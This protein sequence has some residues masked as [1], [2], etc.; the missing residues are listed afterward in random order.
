M[1]LT[2]Q[3]IFNFP[4]LSKLTLIAG[5]GGLKKNV[6]HCGIL[7]YEYDKDVSKKY[8]DYNYQMDGEFLTLTTFLYAKNDPNL[9]YDA[10]KN[11][12][13]KKG[14]GLII[15]NIFKLPISD[16]VIRYANHMNFP[17]FVLNDSYPFFEDIIILINKAMERYESFYYR[18]QK[19]NLLLDESTGDSHT[20][21]KLIYDI[22]PSIQDDILVI[23]FRYNKGSLGPQAYRKIESKIYAENFLSPEDSVFYYENGFM[24]ILSGSGSP[25]EDIYSLIETG[26]H[27]LGKTLTDDFRIGISSIHNMR[28]ELPEAI[29]ESFYALRFSGESENPYTLFN[30]LGPYRAILPN[31]E[32]PH[33]QRYMEDYISPLEK[34][35]TE[36]KSDILS[37]VTEFVKCGGD[38]EKTGNAMGQHKNTIRYRMNRAGEILGINPFAPG[39]YEGLALA[40]R[41]YICS[42]A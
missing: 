31:A 34:Y 6:S 14:S 42:I 18:E 27:T 3:D 20:I 2:V 19:V 28:E 36:K 33:M 12:V 16:N 4:E 15:K 21:K 41:I 32:Q 35:D 5:R 1:K 39:D 38:L 26:F 23:T 7:D 17:I 30:E 24:V 25:A 9:I 10:V 8:Y 40:V 37:T 11:L 22:N 29:R 13:A